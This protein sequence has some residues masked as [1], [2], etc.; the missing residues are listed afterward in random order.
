[1][2]NTSFIAL[3]RQSTLRRQMDIVANNIANMNTGGF[4]AERMMFSEHL[5]RSKGGESYFG[6]KLSY[7]RDIASVRDLSD[8]PIEQ[9]GNPLDVAISGEG[10]FS[11]E[12]DD[13]TRYTRNGRFQ[14]N[15]EGQLVTQGGLPVLTD[16]GTPIFFAPD[17]RDIG[18]ARDGTISTNNGVLGK[19]SLVA[20]ENPQMLEQNAG[21]LYATDEAPIATDDR[22]GII[23]FAVE[24]S[25]VQGILEMTRMIEVHRRYDSVKNFIDK[26][27]E[28]QKKMIKELIS[29]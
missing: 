16:A 23:Q 2:E 22:V 8:G 10:Y 3:S 19:L 4:K 15:Q 17:E 12:T 13:G 1:M 7:V 6:E 9:T 21:G 11:I 27:D 24:G 29:A 18:I 20:F 5:I 25:N 14:L 28:R 26:E